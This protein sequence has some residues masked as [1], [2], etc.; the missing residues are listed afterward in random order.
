[1]GKMGKLGKMGRPM[2]MMGKMGRPMGK[3]GVPMPNINKASLVSSSI[4]DSV[5]S[6]TIQDV[7]GKIA[8][9]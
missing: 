3:F 7:A 1:M 9:Q 2:G 8:K 6:L 4:S 5:N